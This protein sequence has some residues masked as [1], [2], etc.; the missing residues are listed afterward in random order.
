ME[1]REGPFS[2][3]SPVSHDTVTSPLSPHFI[4]PFPKRAEAPI[5]F[6]FLKTLFTFVRMVFKK[7]EKKE[8]IVQ[9]WKVEE[10]PGPSP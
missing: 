7:K 5:V 8:V 10:G 9:S 6:S 3:S 2:C 1:G 4:G